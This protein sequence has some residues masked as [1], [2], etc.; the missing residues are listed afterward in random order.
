[1]TE[2]AIPWINTS[3]IPIIPLE[4]LDGMAPTHLDWEENAGTY[5]LVLE[6]TSGTYMGN[7]LRV[8]YLQDRLRLQ[9]PIILSKARQLQEYY[10]NAVQSL[11]T[12]FDNLPVD[13]ETWR[14][15]VEEPYG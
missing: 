6:Y 14:E 7:T 11:I 13:D 15:I 3:E 2:M 9:W 1:M 4:L 10:P 5:Q 12:L 8:N